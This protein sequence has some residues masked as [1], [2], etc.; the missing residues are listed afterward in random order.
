MRKKPIQSFFI[1]SSWRFI[2]K[3]MLILDVAFAQFVLFFVT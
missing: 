2:D 1:I 3:G